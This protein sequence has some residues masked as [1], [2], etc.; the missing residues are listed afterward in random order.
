M[1]PSCLAPTFKSG[2]SS[3]SIWGG[4][5]YNR[6]SS[7]VFFNKGQRSSNDFIKQVYE[8]VLLDFYN[9]CSTPVLMEDNAPIH[10]AKVAREW[11]DNHQIVRLNWPPQSPDLNPIE[12][13]WMILKRA[14]ERRFE[15][16]RN[17]ESL[18]VLVESEWNLMSIEKINKLI[19]SMPKRMKDVI[20]SKGYLIDY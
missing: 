3:L 1:L 20:R 6:R 2:R 16:V 19:D 7:L 13:L 5:T 12:N 10:T 18:K 9:S 14:K 4:I 8:P 11:K 15:Y 17:I